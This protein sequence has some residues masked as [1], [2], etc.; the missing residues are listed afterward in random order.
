MNKRVSVNIK[1][2]RSA[3]KQGQIDILET[4]YKYRFGSRS[5]IAGLL[6]IND[7]TLY[8][9]LCVLVR[10]GL[11]G[12]KLENKSRIKGLPVAYYLTPK[13]LKFL[14]SLGDHAFVTDK[15]IKASYRDKSASE[16]IIIHS[17]SVFSQI[18]ALK[19][20]YPSLKAY[21][22]RDMSRFDYFPANPPDA[23]LSLANG[24]DIK[25]FFIDI[26]PDNQERK[27]FFQKVFAYITFFEKGDWDITNTEIPSLLFIA[28]NANTEYRIR[29]LI[30][31]AI[32]KIELD[33]DL[34]I[35]T[36]TKNAIEHMDNEA[37]V[38]TN[39]NDDELIALSDM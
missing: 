13:G 11:V 7:S 20:R 15:I 9:K 3:I 21:L 33:E 38:W 17:L 4:L 39:I 8:K 24:D 16:P 28:E 22:R 29:R 34:D 35:Y 6:N 25:R 36:T 27:V 10:H 5:L 12:S 18:I 26:I 32:N 31:G 30:K 2:G 37:L 1:D 14:Q 23:F 19:R